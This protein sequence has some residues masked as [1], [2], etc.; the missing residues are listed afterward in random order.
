MLDG[1]GILKLGNFCLSKGEGE[2]VKDVLSVLSIYESSKVQEIKDEF[3][4]MQK[5]LKG[6]I[7]LL[8]MM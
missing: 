7:T 5:R 3:H 4:S 8:L 6:Q 1:S 2:T